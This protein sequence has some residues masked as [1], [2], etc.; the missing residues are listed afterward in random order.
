MA[1][2]II[3]SGLPGVGKTTIAKELA[4]RLPAMLIRVDTIEHALKAGGIEDVGGSGYMAGYALATANLRL[5]HNVIADSVNPWQLT[6]DAWRAAGNL[7]DAQILEVEVICSDADEH[8]R[9]VE[10]RAP[11]IPGFIVP[12]W[13]EVEERD[14]HAWVREVHTI[15]TATMDTVAS[16]EALQSM[17]CTVENQP[18]LPTIYPQRNGDK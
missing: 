2:F 1:H 11:D 16:A 18:D 6:R 5:G 8:R 10:I 13:A 12:T 4:K 17:L 15:D 7:A 3:L 9:R 14:Y